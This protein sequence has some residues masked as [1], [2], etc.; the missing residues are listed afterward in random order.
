MTKVPASRIA[1]G[2]ATTD[3]DVTAAFELAS[4]VFGPNQFDAERTKQFVLEHV[5]PLRRRD[6]LTLAKSEG[7]VV[8]LVRRVSRRLR[9]GGVS[10]AAT[11]ITSVAVAPQLRGKGIGR[12]L[13]H[14]AHRHGVACGDEVAVLY[15]RRAVDGWYAQLGYL[16]IG[17]HVELRLTSTDELGAS[18]L[19]IRDGVQPTAISA[20]AAAYASTYRAVPGHFV[21]SRDFWRRLA[22]RLTLR[23]AR[24]LTLVAGRRTIG[25]AH[26][27]GHDVWELAVEAAHRRDA[28]AA[29]AAE[30]ARRTRMAPVFRLAPA[31]PAMVALQSLNH[32]LSVRR[33]WNGGHMACPLTARGRR[34]LRQLGLASPTNAADIT[35]WPTWSPLDEF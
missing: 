1:I 10:M 8:G 6:N 25:Y 34:H 33:A 31:H 21:R 14:A 18:Q 9:F 24:F 27:E 3:R 13:M 35:R 32:T 16:G 2:P 26:V 7:E 5:E 11:G 23:S 15:A 17:Q 19:G 29:V 28:I 4:R 30:V 20:Y 22:S 12:Q